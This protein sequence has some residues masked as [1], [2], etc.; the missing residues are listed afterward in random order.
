MASEQITPLKVNAHLEEPDD[1]VENR[2]FREL[3]GSRDLL[4]C[5]KATRSRPVSLHRTP[6]V[7]CSDC[8]TSVVMTNPILG[9]NRGGRR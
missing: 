5:C 3:V 9:G 6:L 7:R 2:P 8:S 1:G 4:R